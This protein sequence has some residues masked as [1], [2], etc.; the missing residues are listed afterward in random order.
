[1][2]W[3]ISSCVGHPWTQAEK[4]VV[5][6]KATSNPVNVFISA[7]WETKVL[8][9][10]ACVAHLLMSCASLRRCTRAVRRKRKVFKGL[11]VLDPL[12]TLRQRCVSNATARQHGSG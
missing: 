12:A 10:Q 6:V 11:M 1:M 9:K 2:D 7:Q 4:E 3:T 8:Q 5:H